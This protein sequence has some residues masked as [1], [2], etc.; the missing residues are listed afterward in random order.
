MSIVYY[1]MP[2][3]NIIPN[4]VQCMRVCVYKMVK[5]VPSTI[6]VVQIAAFNISLL[7]DF[8]VDR[9]DRVEPTISKLINITGAAMITNCS[10]KIAVLH[11]RADICSMW[12]HSRV[13]VWVNKIYYYESSFLAG[14]SNQIHFCCGRTCSH[15]HVSSSVITTN[16]V[17]AWAVCGLLWTTATYRGS[18][19]HIAKCD[20][21]VGPIANNKCGC[22]SIPLHAYPD[23][24]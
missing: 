21:R 4:K 15:I 9:I 20:W 12:W 5:I 2:L 13:C 18:H 3:R 14:Q 22:D 10:H 6:N 1:T 11:S 23:L 17:I 16:T 7:F 8:D 19:C 24:E